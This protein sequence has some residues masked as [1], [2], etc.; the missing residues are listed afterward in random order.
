MAVA[1]ALALL[2]VQVDRAPES[3][4]A[5]FTYHKCGSFWFKGR[6]TLFTHKYRC[7]KAQ[8]K[9]KRRFS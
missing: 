3:A 7:A 5:A 4:R 1:L 9:A 8:R 2:V 6:H